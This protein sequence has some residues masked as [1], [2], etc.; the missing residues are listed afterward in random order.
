MSTGTKLSEQVPR[1]G[2]GIPQLG[3][4]TYRSQGDSLK[5]ALKHAIKCGYR[6]IDTAYV[7]LNEDVIG[8]TLKEVIDESN[9]TL[10]REDF[11]LVSKVWCTHHSKQAVR[12]ALQETLKNLQTD[13]LDLYLIHF[14]MGFK[15]GTGELPFPKD[16][17]GEPIFSDICY[18]ET[19]QAM[20][21][22]HKEGL[23]KN[24]GLSNFTLTQLQDVMKNCT[25][26]PQ[27]LQI[28]VSP[29]LQNDDYVDFC[30]NNNIVITAYGILGSGEVPTK[31]NIPMLLKNETLINIGKKYNKSP[32]QVC[33]R[34]GIQRNFVVLAK[35]TIPSE[36]CEN[37]K[38]FD[39]QLSDSD[40]VA[41]KDLHCDV[42]HLVGLSIFKDHKFYPF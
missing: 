32:A 20:E 27:N 3:F 37:L 40:M 41:I 26:K 17:K 16:D 30:Q 19:Q 4:G 25:I 31:P 8:R 10:K 42:R 5:D 36:I 28:E 12:Q 29:Y 13:Y 7:Y 11:F 22:L 35:S 39:F 18:L 21:E 14:P 15:E 33:L 6:H 24:I 34:W 38:V 9:G 2:F 23:I 1:I